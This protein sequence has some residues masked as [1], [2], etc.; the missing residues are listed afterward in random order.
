MAS[1]SMPSPTARAEWRSYWT[2]PIA[3]GLGYATSVIHIYGL[4]VYI[5]PI[6]ESFGWSR[7]TTTAGLTIATLIQAVFGVPIGM[8]VDRMGPRPLG[9]FGVP[10][11]CA[12]FALL[13]TASGSEW[14]W[15]GLWV[16]MAFAT[17]PVQATIWTAAVASRFEASR[18]LAFAITL[19][20]A[21]VAAALFPW[22]GS[23]LIAHFGWQTAMAYQALV[24]VA[25]AL[26]VIFFCFRGSRDVR[27]TAGQ[28]PTAAA[29]PAERDGVG[30][31]EGLKSTVYI[32]LL[33]ASL[34]FTFTILALVVHFV[35]ILT[36]SGIGA[37]AAAG[38]AALIG[39]FS[40]IGRLCTGFLLDRLPASLVGAA[41]FTMPMLASV[42]LLGLGADGAG[43]A[44]VLI[45]LTLGAEVDVIVYLSTRH[46]GLKAFGALYGGLLVALSVGTATGPLAA[47]AVFDRTGTYDLFLYATL[48]MMLAASMFLL[49]LP[50]PAFGLAQEA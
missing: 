36:G 49:S 23:K 33:L 31:L 3:A 43:P 8:L 21:S 5:E 16:V 12:A 11:A 46:F 28:E 30:F 25:I 9:V 38:L 45:G 24:W 29:A 2:L 7:A 10:L 44:A 34:L 14:E 4:G 39:I 42:C 19:C 32:R 6:S 18:G 47:A 27:K 13:G 17:L 40:I 26:P 37:E 22:L 1:S 20:G 41:V 15:Y 50:K 48:G 35:P